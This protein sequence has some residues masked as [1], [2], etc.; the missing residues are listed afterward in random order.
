MT[1]TNDK[2]DIIFSRRGRLER[3]SERMESRIDNLED[4]IEDL[5]PITDYKKIQRIQNRID[6]QKDALEVNDYLVDKL[7]DRL[8]QDDFT[9]TYLENGQ[10][11]IKVTDSPY[12]DTYVGG[13]SLKFSVSGV[14]GTQR[15]TSSVTIE[16]F[17]D[18]VGTTFAGSSSFMDIASNYSDVTATL[19]DQDNNALVT[20]DNF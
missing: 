15:R 14:K 4:R 17:E 6:K 19:Y 20:F 1:F 2:F 13:T 3:R 5:D 11:D 18:E 12:D 7:T 9:I 8:P 10:F 16:S